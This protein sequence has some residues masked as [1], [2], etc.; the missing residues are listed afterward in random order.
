MRAL[1]TGVTGQDGAYLAEL[2][3]ARGYEVLGTH[4]PRVL[5]ELWRLEALGVARG[6]NLIPFDLTEIGAAQQLIDWTT[7][8]E[9]YNLAA[10]SSVAASFQAPIDTSEVN[11]LGALRLL[12]AVRQVK[13][14]IRFFQASS[15]EMF[16]LSDSWP[17]SEQ[18]PFRPLNPYGV[19]KLHA[20]LSVGVYRRAFGL[21]AV[22]GI[23]FSHESPLRGEQFVSRKIIAGMVRIARRE[24]EVLELGN[25]D[26]RRDWGFA[27]DYA[28]AIWLALQR[29]PADDY[30]IASGQTYS[31][32]E[33]V[34]RVAAVLDLPLEWRGQGLQEVALGPDG[35]VMVRINPDCVRPNESTVLCG[36]ADK[37]ARVLGWRARLSFDALVEQMVE[38]ESNRSPVAVGGV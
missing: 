21:H 28:E 12:E 23:L 22:S 27:G 1:I 7:P 15:Q 14:D 19:A 26:A 3:L 24:Q 30:V 6:V 29:K 9:I 37:A 35:R 4:R 8:D 2:L 11:A 18:T 25:L 20:H 10:Q 32:R 16:G 33:L 17:Q 38:V 31:V 36:D 13:P 5:P 34:N